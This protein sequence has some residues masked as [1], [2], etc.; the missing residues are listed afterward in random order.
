MTIILFALFSTVLCSRSEVQLRQKLMEQYNP[1]ER[2][3]K[4]YSDKVVVT[5]GIALQQ[6]IS[7]HYSVDSSFDST[8]KADLVNY[9]NGDMTW[10]PPGILKVS[11]KID[12]YWFPF[13]EQ[14]CFFKF[15]AWTYNG[16]QLDL[17]EGQVA[18]Q[19][20]LE[21]GQWALLKAWAVRTEDNYGLAETYPDIKIYMRLRRRTLY[22]AFNLIMPCML[23]VILIVLGFTLSP[24]SCEKV[25]LQISVSLAIIIFLTIVNDMTPPTSEAVPLLGVFF[26]TC[27]YISVAATAFT[28]YVQA[29]H[30]RDPENSQRMG[31]WMHFMLLELI[32]YLLAIKRP[33]RKNNW[34]TI[35]E[36]W[37]NRGLYDPEEGYA[38]LH[39]GS[40][41]FS[42]LDD[43]KTFQSSSL[44]KKALR[45]NFQNLLF[46][47]EAREQT[48]KTQLSLQR[49][50][51][52]NRIYNHVKALR[53]G[54]E[55]ESEVRSIGIEYQFAALVFDRLC[56]V[57]FT[58]VMILTTVIN[59]ARA[60]YLFA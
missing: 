60:P 17:Q 26:H 52:L 55:D 20:Y 48:Q 41:S 25:G 13:D 28:V 59:A 34:Q 44:I 37:R 27:V 46:Q 9:Y 47:L 42:D 23:T 51:V 6:I 8:Y 39:V 15:G 4:N 29:I 33:K 50:K 3:V 58:T 10:N 5:L 56:L 45:E 30:F 24:Q 2:P 40:L 31:F 1:L 32:P 53:K 11:C 7:L 43:T 21:S 12:I 19:E 16:A 49:I 22:Y 38:S 54:A 57:L 35:K 36:S 18:L 14:T